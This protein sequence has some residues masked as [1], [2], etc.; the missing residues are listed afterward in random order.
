MFDV[1]ALVVHHLCFMSR[2]AAR[3]A[4]YVPI[5]SLVALGLS[6][7]LPALAWADEGPAGGAPVDQVAIGGAVLVLLTAILLAI[8]F[9]HRA[10]RIA[11][12]GRLGDFSE[13]VSGLPRWC[14]MPATVAGSALVVAVF[15]FYWD[16]ATHISRG[17]DP[18]PF[19]TAAHY[20]IL[21]GLYGIA[22]AGGLALVLG[23]P[24]RLRSTV[25]IRSGWSV[26]VG[27]LL[28]FVC[29]AVALTGFPLDDVWHT[30]FGEDV[31]LWGPT[32]ILMIGGASLGTL[33]L[34]VLLREGDRARQEEVDTRPEPLWLRLRVVAIAGAFLLG[35][36]TL[37]AEFDYGVPQF[38]LVYQPILIAIAA[39][40]GLVPA[41]L[42]LGR[43]GAIG[44]VVFFILIR[45]TLTLVIGPGFGQPILH[46]PLY[47]PEAAL[48]ELV[49]WRLDER[50]PVLMGAVSGLLIGTVGLAAEWGWSHLWMPLPWTESMLGTALPLAL[51]AALAG[52]LI[53][54]F[55]AG[56]LDADRR[57]RTG[58]WWLAALAGGAVVFC[59]GFPLP[60]NS[61]T[62]VK[63]HVTLIPA[64]GGPRN[65][66]NVTARLT[67]SNAARAA[68]WLTI[69]AWQG[70]ADRGLIVDR[71]RR[72]APGTYTST[73]PIPVYG[74]WKTMIRLARG[75]AL[76]AV[77][78]YLPRDTEIPAPAITPS[79]SLTRPFVR[80]HKILQRESHGGAAAVTVPAYLLLVAIACLWFATITFGLRRLA[81]ALTERRGV[82]P[83][84]PS[85]PPGERRPATISLA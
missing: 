6:L 30:L 19:G 82:P 33:A 3:H 9:A 18:G 26:P 45:G 70:Q 35:L 51:L 15:G 76:D 13:R 8:G 20:P 49:A 74:N 77:P 4:V 68:E 23:A 21:I 60:M 43:G 53:G 64:A 25:R 73:K 12:L 63:A 62:P 55:I 47:L 46:F 66:V 32:H 5:A 24:A 78:I 75:R 7:A 29:G 22:L 79:P 67:P 11:W 52:G 81:R 1:T 71:M 50:R 31:T 42:Y 85:P 80:D 72:R 14:A 69:T 40:V 10:G 38:Q 84:Q 41:R 83:P 65:T 27:G 56:A 17:R 61:G 54:G 28:V 39:S 44:A 37:Q 34:W 36:S 2:R 58:P 48:V 59:I 16:V 57:P